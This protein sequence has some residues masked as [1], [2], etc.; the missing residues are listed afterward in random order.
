[1]TTYPFT[2]TVDG[3]VRNPCMS[4]VT[5]TSM[6]IYKLSQGRVYAFKVGEEFHNVSDMHTLDNLFRTLK[7]TFG[8]APSA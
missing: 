7:Q 8:T 1:M 5:V 4:E 6:T 3:E 2:Y